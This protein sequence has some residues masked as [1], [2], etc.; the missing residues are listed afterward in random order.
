M[1]KKI[2]Y[3]LIGVLL[4]AFCAGLWAWMLGW[5]AR[6]FP[7]GSFDNAPMMK[8][9]MAPGVMGFPALVSIII[10]LAGLL[11]VTGVLPRPASGNDDSSGH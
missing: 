4:L 10:G 11:F 9:W 7:P 3:R 1:T 2:A 6:P 8:A 5:L